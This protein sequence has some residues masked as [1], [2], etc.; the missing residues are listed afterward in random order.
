MHTLLHASGLPK[1]LLGETAHHV[2]W[3]MNCST[4]TKA[5]EGKAYF[6][7]V[8]EKKPDLGDIYEWGEKMWIHVENGDKLRG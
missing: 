3:L 2:V 1:I 5:V 6:E 8:F 4:T 7:A